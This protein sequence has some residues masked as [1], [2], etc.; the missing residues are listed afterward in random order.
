[1]YRRLHRMIRPRLAAAL[2]AIGLAFVASTL[3]GAAAPALRWSQDYALVVLE[4]G[5]DVHAARRLVQSAGGS[6]ALLL[7]PRLLT[8]WIDPGLDA[9]L[10]GRAGIRSIH[11]GAPDAWPAD[12]DGPAVRPG[13]G[14]FARATR[15]ELDRTAAADVAAARLD[16]EPLDLALRPDARHPGPISETDIAA[17]LS[18]LGVAARK[19]GAGATL[20]SNSDY[21]TGTVAV[22]LFFVESAGGGAD[23]DLYDWTVS[24]E[25]AV[26]DEAAAALSWWSAQARAQGACWV[27]FDL[28]ARFATADAR[29]SQWRELLL[30][31]ST[32]VASAVEQI[33]GNF[34]YTS[35]N[36]L[37]RAAAFNAAQRVTRGTDWAFCSFVT[38]NPAGPK[39]F[40]DG[41]AAWSWLGGPY[42]ALLQR[43]FDWSFRQVFAHESAHIF[44]ACDEY[45][46]PGYG[47]CTDCGGCADTG[48]PNGNC[49]S[50]NADPETCMMRS[51]DW[52]LCSF[53]A[54]QVGWWR[55]P[56]DGGAAAPPRLD[57]AA[58]SALPQ[59]LEADLEL[60]GEH[61]AFGMTAQLG[62]G[63]H[64]LSLER[65]SATSVRLRVRIDLEAAPGRRD[66][67]LTAPDG[68]TTTLVGGFEVRA[69]PRHFVSAAGAHVFPYASPAEAARDLASALAACSRGDTL[70]L[71]GGS[72]AP[73]QLDKTLH[74]QGG[75][76]DDFG[77]RAPAFR[78]TVV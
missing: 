15:G 65:P 52:A 72:Y 62:P 28:Q 21:M 14:F 68:Q 35:G 30:H 34:G 20:A 64:V 66:L 55:D 51:N 63:V 41:Y 60:Q 53:T 39:Q 33:L 77:A 10:R 50:C 7:P 17:N 76:T 47:G 70:L 42:T 48:V 16:A 27:S 24:A 36:H 29:C 59:G 2:A 4:D 1:M 12:L 38:A 61:F 22:T 45:Y 71:V 75:W 46:T 49:E 25:Q 19:A 67:V 43:S 23:P 78:P 3:H 56:C 74:V 13:L 69:T 18:R 31:P 58:P 26:F 73:F 8:G 5:A 32:D 40:T 57:A 37:A 54:G 6:V 9:A 44:R 11:R